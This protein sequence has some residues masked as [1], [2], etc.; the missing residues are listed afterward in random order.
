MQFTPERLVSGC[1]RLAPEEFLVATR[2]LKPDNRSVPLYDLFGLPL[3]LGRVRCTAEEITQLETL[4][5]EQLLAA[6]SALVGGAFSMV[7]NV[8]RLMKRKLEP[9]MYF[10]DNAI[11][12]PGNTTVIMRAGIRPE[13]MTADMEGLKA[14]PVPRKN[15]LSTIVFY[16]VRPQGAGRTLPGFVLDTHG[17][18]VMEVTGFQIGREGLLGNALKGLTYPRFRSRQVHMTT[19]IGA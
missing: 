13:Q 14:Y 8:Q 7:S 12:N 10:T 2:T 5:E 15:A 6:E 9:M 17:K 3:W 1:V 4:R 18:G 19:A 11:L 16:K